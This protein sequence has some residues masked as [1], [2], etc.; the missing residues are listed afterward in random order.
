MAARRVETELQKW[1]RL[2]RM[3]IWLHDHKYVFQDIVSDEQLAAAKV[4]VNAYPAYGLDVNRLG[5]LE[6]MSLAKARSLTVVSLESQKQH[7]VDRPKIPK[8]C[9]EF[10][11]G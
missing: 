3:K 7:R 8:V 11:M 9:Q 10:G 1:Q 5:D 4:I 6:V 2:G